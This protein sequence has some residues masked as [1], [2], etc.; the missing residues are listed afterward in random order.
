M[1]R[2]LSIILFILLSLS[3]YSQAHLPTCNYRIDYTHHIVDWD[4]ANRVPRFVYYVVKGDSLRKFPRKSFRADELIVTS[5]TPSDYFMSGYDKGHMLPH[6][7]AWNE[8]MSYESSFMTNIAP[9]TPGLNRGVWKSMEYMERKMSY[10]YCYVITGTHI[11]KKN[12]KLLNKRVRIPH[13][14]WKVIYN[15]STDKLL[16]YYVTQYSRGSAENFIISLEKLE[17]LIDI[18]FDF[19][20]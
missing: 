13:A 12:M 18:D 19:N 6:A 20:N 15:P 17:E 10:P 11:N 1:K 2:Y 16:V 9:Q 14:F 7:S 8:I 3:V 4:R 5:S